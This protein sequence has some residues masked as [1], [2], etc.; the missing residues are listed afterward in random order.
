[1]NKGQ[2]SILALVIVTIFITAG[3]FLPG[4]IG[5]GDL[6]PSST[7]GSTMHTLEDIYTI[8]SDTNT[9]VNP[10]PCS[11]GAPVKKSG[12]QLSYETGDD[13]DLQKGVTWPSPRF[14]DNGDGTVT[15][16]LTSLIWLKD[17]N[18]FGQRIWTDALNDSNSLAS[19]S[20]GLTDNSAAGDWR[21][22]N[23]YE[24]QSLVDYGNSNPS[25]SSQ[26]PSY[27]DV[28]SSNY[29]SSTTQASD[30]LKAWSITFHNGPLGIRVKTDSHY[31]WP[32]RG[33]N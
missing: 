6:E 33:G 16:N 13:G 32:V 8:V 9:K 23:V 26:H 1:M 7:P 14:T 28:L 12:Q 25:L 29:W 15:D 2:R 19:G 4:L 22:P 27:N 30:I 21:L 24:I 5:A 18:C 3:L 31:V 11:G 20:C 17:P 10:E